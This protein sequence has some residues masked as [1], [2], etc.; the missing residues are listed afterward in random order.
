MKRSG[1]HLEKIEKKR[2]RKKYIRSD[3]GKEKD[4]ERFTEITTKGRK[5]LPSNLIKYHGCVTKRKDRWRSLIRKSEYI[6]RAMYNTHATKEEAIAHIKE[7]N[8]NKGVPIKN[9]IY[10]YQGDYY[11]VLTQNQIMKFSVENID[12]VEGHNWFAL[13]DNR[14]A[15]Y[16][17]QT[18]MGECTNISFHRMVIPSLN[19][20]ETVD[21]ISRITLDNTIPNLR[22]ASNKTQGINQRIRSDNKTTVKGVSYNEY[23]NCYLVTWRDE[24]G[25]QKNRTFAVSKHGPEAFDKAVAYRKEIEDTLPHYVLALAR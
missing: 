1:T 22:M 19:S 13:Y 15:S 2:I 11:C 7:V 14:T 24:N 4:N 8:I 3:E 21:H 6:P 10:V 16:Y 12:I 20:N 25:N 23:K 17:A 18:R 5:I 9:V